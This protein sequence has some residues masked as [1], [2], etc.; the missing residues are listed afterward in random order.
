MDVA[1]N[2]IVRSREWPFSLEKKKIKIK[3]R[4]ESSFSVPT[5]DP[6]INTNIPREEG[7][8]GVG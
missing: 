2:E 3:K 7:G 8:E 4:G 6:L 5:L 1:L